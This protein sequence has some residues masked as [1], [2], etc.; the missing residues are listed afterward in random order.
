MSVVCVAAE[1]LAAE[2]PLA[3]AG[4]VAA[5][6][7][8]S[9]G[10][11]LAEEFPGCAAVVRV[12]EAFAWPSGKASCQA[13]GRGPLQERKRARPPKSK[14]FSKS[15]KVFLVKPVAEVFL[16]SRAGL[17]RKSLPGHLVVGV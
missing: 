2:L 13:P 8:A 1:S 5:S 6:G 3:G 14:V 7:A 17:L 11:S 4:A 10:Q 16:G 9:R 15:A 12:L